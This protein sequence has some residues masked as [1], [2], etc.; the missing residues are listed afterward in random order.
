MASPVSEATADVIRSTNVKAV[1]T[2][3]KAAPE[4]R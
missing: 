2:S 1:S 3:E 4:A